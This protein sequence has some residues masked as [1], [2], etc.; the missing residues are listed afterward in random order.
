M[1]CEVCGKETGKGK[2]VVIDGN[3]MIACMSCASFG[4][5]KEEKQE[6]V[7]FMKQVLPPDFKGKEFDLGLDIVEDYGRRVRQARDAKGLTVK[8]LAMKIFE[9]ESL[10]HRI[11]NQSIKPSDEMI[12]KIEKELG[13]KLKKQD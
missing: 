12:G 9:K 1:E 6:Q 5:E 7:P 10:L 8:E 3:T 2:L 4:K 13:I 11:E